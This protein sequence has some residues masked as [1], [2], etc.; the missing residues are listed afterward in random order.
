VQSAAEGLTLAQ[1]DTATHK[2]TPAETVRLEEL[3]IVV[4][5]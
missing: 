4:A 5:A 1:L 3:V 2:S